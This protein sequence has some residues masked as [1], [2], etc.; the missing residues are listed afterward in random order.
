MEYDFRNHPFVQ[1]AQVDQYQ[2][3]VKQ[4]QSAML[5]GKAVE[6]MAINQAKQALDQSYERTLAMLENLDKQHFPEKEQSER[7]CFPFDVM[8]KFLRDTAEH[9]SIMT[10]QPSS[11]ANEQHNEQ[12]KQIEALK[13]AELAL[14]KEINAL[15]S[16]LADEEK[17]RIDAS[18]QAEKSHKA[19]LAA[20]RQTRK[21]KGELELATNLSQ[22]LEQ[23]VSQYKLDLTNSQT[24]N[25]ALNDANQQLSKKLVELEQQLVIASKAEK[26]GQQEGA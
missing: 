12:E 17:A 2:E 5:A 21:V 25:A 22:Q 9:W 3:W 6:G 18:A 7:L 16:Q 20:Q 13:V 4:F 19:K 1:F 10:G 24:E 11:K 8:D 23:Q 15:A 26:Q 14:K